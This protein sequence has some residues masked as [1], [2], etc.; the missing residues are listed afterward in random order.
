MSKKFKIIILA[1]VVLILAGTLY[2]LNADVNTNKNQVILEIAETDVE[3]ITFK[4]YYSENS[5][6]ITKDIES[7]MWKCGEDIALKKVF[8][9]DIFNSISAIRAIAE[10]ENPDSLSAY[11]LD[12]AKVVV[13]IETTKGDYEILIGDYNEVQKAYYIKLA[14]K[15]YIAES[16][17]KLN[18]A[19]NY[20][21][22]L[23][24]EA[25]EK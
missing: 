16:E 20:D 9:E 2:F 22:K 15:I 14:D 25:Q 23:F 11:G 4:A 6:V 13:N 3:Q 17:S 21:T 12:P 19:F 5:V 8:K 7:G 18:Y 1:V 10:I 24:I